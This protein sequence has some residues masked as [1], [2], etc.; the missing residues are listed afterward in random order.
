MMAT[1]IVRM[2]LMN[3]KPVVCNLTDA[4]GLLKTLAVLSCLL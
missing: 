3:R 4:A 2:D 1:R